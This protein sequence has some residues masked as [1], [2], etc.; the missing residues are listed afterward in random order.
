[1]LDLSQARMETQS[2]EDPTPR[3]Q[4]DVSLRKMNSK[5]LVK[6]LKAMSKFQ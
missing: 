4:E 1:M 3:S 6:D 2:S 5:R